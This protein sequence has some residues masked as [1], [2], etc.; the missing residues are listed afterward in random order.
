M[1]YSQWGLNSVRH[2][3]A[4]KQQHRNCEHYDV[5]ESQE[6]SQQIIEPGI[7]DIPT[8]KNSKELRELKLLV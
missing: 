5:S 4:T 7:N 1:G 6:N 2:D 3:L 8:V